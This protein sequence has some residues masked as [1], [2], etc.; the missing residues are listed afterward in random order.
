MLLKKNYVRLKT[1]LPIAVGTLVCG[2]AFEFC[3]TAAV[4]PGAAIAQTSSPLQAQVPRQPGV[5]LQGSQIILNGRTLSAPWAQW[6]TPAGNRIGISDIG[7]SKTLGVQ[8]LNTESPSL[9]PVHWFNPASQPALNLVTRRTNT[10]RYLDITDLAR[11][12]SWQVSIVGTALQITTSPAQVLS[13]RQGK[14]PWGD[15]LVIEVAQPT[16]WQ[17]ESSAQ[18]LVVSLDAQPNPALLQQMAIS[19]GKFLQSMQIEPGVNQ[20]RLRLRLSSPAGV[21]VWSL[22]GPNRIVVDLRPDS[23]VEQS[24][25]WAPGMRWRQQL[26]TLG[27]Q[28]VPV[29]WLEIN[30]KQ[31]GLSLQPILPNPTMMMGTA[32]LLQ[33]AQQAQV[34]AAI[35]GGFFNRN[36]QL[37][38]GAVRWN[39]RWLS[40]PILNR[41]AIA[42][43]AAGNH[44]FGRL[45]LQE[46][47]ITPTNQRL[48]ITHLNSG[49]IQAG[50][51]RY[52][53]E[54]GSTYT[55]IS[56]NEIIVF[57]QNNQVL[58]QQVIEKSGTGTV[59]I[60]PNGYIL[61][62]RSNQSAANAFPPG[63]RL[64]VESTTLPGD[65]NRYPNIIAAG[66]LLVQ[67][68]QVVVDPNAEGF[69]KAFTIEK[70]SRSAIAQTV[71]GSILLVA[72]HNRVNGT[73]LTLTEF[74]Q[75]LQQMGTVNALNLDGGS[76]TSLYLGGQ[77]IDR[78]QG[79]AAR[80]HSGIGVFLNSFP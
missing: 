63:T 69:S 46:T 27:T 10:L 42:W 7:L 73:G 53:P 20:T 78:S 41:G 49:Y 30:P 13:L 4:K 6:Q 28:Q 23:L 75:L 15:R 66:P 60:P 2:M 51:A 55:T 9:Q 32:P 21:R 62:L 52:T 80:V 68:R 25:L 71:D 3:A 72:T 50:I 48:P 67:N 57:V 76:S 35:N 39:S 47:V 34:A 1:V 45:S 64:Q 36:R 26:L 33:T 11:Q 8:L 12:R 79:S 18:E 17:V 43:D 14:Q 56:D 54:W 77:V 16:P 40:G 38:L 58:Q 59:P 44:L 61:V 70:A 31:P 65:F 22:A 37:P 29:F 5:N 24:I 74:A 19:P